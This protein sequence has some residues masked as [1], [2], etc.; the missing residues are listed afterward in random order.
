[1]TKYITLAPLYQFLQTGKTSEGVLKSVIRAL[2]RATPDI[3][4]KEDQVT[5]KEEICAYEH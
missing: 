1:M 5:Q 4:L 3:A 2:R